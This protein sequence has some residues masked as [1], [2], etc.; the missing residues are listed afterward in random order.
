MRVMETAVIAVRTNK[1][2]LLITWIASR[3]YTVHHSDLR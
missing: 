3:D 1:I 2:D